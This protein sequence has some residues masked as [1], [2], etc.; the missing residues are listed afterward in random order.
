MA[1]CSSSE[2]KPAC[3][4]NFSTGP[5]PFFSFP[6]F[7][8]EA[9][10]EF[11]PADS[12][13]EESSASTSFDSGA[14]RRSDL[15]SSS[16]SPASDSEPSPVSASDDLQSELVSSSD[17][18]SLLDAP[19]SALACAEPACEVSET[20]SEACPADSAM[21]L[22]AASASGEGDAGGVAFASDS[23]AAGEAA[24]DSL[25]EEVSSGES[26][27]DDPLRARPGIF[28]ARPDLDPCPADSA[29]EAKIA[30]ESRC[31][32]LCL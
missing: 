6:V 4:S 7:S 20:A 27:D 31:P 10:F 5:W 15:G 9:E 26:S 8:V 30:T 17:A 28:K 24:S 1:M 23:V 11:E 32:S 2:S 12:A 19:A 21:A 18:A 22:L 25:A 3:G 13:A 14:E 29:N 16:F